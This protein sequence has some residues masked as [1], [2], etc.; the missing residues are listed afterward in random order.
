MEIGEKLAKQRRQ[1]G[2][3][4]EDI[5]SSTG[6]SVR[7]VL[8]IES[9]ADQF[10]S[11]SEMSRMIRLYARKLGILVEPD[12]AALASRRLDPEVVTPALIPRFLLK[13][14]ASRPD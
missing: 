12:P 6:M 3:A 14:E 4:V 8:A 5:A 11:A 13:H 7:Q 1:L 2:L 10:A 9:G